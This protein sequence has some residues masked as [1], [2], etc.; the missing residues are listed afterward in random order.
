MI[1][2]TALL[3]SACVALSA[4]PALA[5]NQIFLDGSIAA[6]SIYTAHSATPSSRSRSA[7][8]T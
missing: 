1:R 5:D 4:A 2:K 8:W 6:N 7:S 3:A